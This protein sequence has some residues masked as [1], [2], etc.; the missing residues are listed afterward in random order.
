MKT[1]RS[2]LLVGLALFL[3]AC[4]QPLPSDKSNYA[5]DWRS[6][7]MQIIITQDGRVQY[8]RSKGTGTTKV[9][10]PIQKFEGNDFTV[11][12]AFVTTKF[13]VS[14]PPTQEG[15]VWKMTVDGVELTRR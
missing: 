1:L 2:L 5:G 8:A 10:G 12:F 11:G 14:K 7:I 4:G 9:Q 15:G 6:D 13:V 3:A